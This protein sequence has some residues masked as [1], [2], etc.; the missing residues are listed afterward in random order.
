VKNRIL[1]TGIQ[2]FVGRYLAAHWVR[3]DP[4]AEIWGLGRSIQL[5][6]TFTHSIRWASQTFQAPLPASLRSSGFR[7]LSMDILQ[8][9]MLIDFLR[10]Y[11]PTVVIHLASLLPGC[12]P[13]Q[14]LHTN[15]DGTVLLTEAIAE[16]GVK[17]KK[18]VISSSSAVYGAQDD[19]N[20]PLKEAGPCSPSDQYGASKLAAEHASRIVALE[21]SIPTLWARTFNAVG[22]GQHETH[23]FGQIAR[24]TASISKGIL[25]PELTVRSLDTTRDYVDVHDVAIGLK[26]L[27]DRG[28]PDT[29][30][31]LASGNEVS[32]R[33]VAQIFLTVAGLRGVKIEQGGNAPTIRRHFASIGRI[34]SLGF[35]PSLRLEQS[36]ADALAYYT[37]EV[38]EKAELI[39]QPVP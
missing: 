15:V 34:E 7:Y 8:K 17:I 29:V 36:A 27:A 37:H 25:P 19:A 14:M 5:L 12:E 38:A 10:E 28:R 18:L 9:A 35:N 16:S 23:L 6:D 22:A 1:I 21:R 3:M 24:A 11:Q 32:A 20:L 13:E 30:Y 4:A 33:S 2:G 31:N 39:T 26:L